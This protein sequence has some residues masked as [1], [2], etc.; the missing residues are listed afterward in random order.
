[1]DALRR[2][3]RIMKIEHSHRIAQQAQRIL[4]QKYLLL[5]SL[6]ICNHSHHIQVLKMY[7]GATTQHKMSEGRNIF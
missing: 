6:N 4:P 5:F 2:P 7:L 1:M 3:V